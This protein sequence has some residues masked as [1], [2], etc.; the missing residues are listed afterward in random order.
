MS[1]TPKTKGKQE[2][3]RATVTAAPRPLTFW[4]QYRRKPQGML[5]LALVLIYVL[6][7]IFA[8]VIA[9]YDPLSDL[10]L[11]DSVAAP[12][13][14]GKVF[15]KYQDLPPTI[16]LS[17]GHGS[18]RSSKMKTLSFLPGTRLPMKVLR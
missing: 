18:G 10:Y 7:A 6:V 11:A 13:W 16:R 15:G 12:A 3:A 1:I 4:E 17:L 2:A 8:P 14:L 9:P 5:G